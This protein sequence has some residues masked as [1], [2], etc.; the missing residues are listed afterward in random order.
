MPAADHAG[1]HP[2]AD[3]DAKHRAQ[4]VRATIYEDARTVAG[5]LTGFDE[6]QVHAATIAR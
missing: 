4:V 5:E 6:D 3:R 1:A 2:T